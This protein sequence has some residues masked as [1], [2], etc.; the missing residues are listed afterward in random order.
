MKNQIY[1]FCCHCIRMTLMSEDGCL[2]CGGKFVVSGIKDS[3]NK[4]K[5]KQK[6]EAP[7]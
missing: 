4:I 2:F 6:S 5:R 7:Y 1:R 3:F